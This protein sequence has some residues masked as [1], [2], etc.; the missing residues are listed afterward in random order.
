[1]VKVEISNQ[2][3]EDFLEEKNNLESTLSTIEIL[4]DEELLREIDTANEEIERGDCRVMS[5]KEIDNL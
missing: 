4:Q 5:Y 1:M 2:L 3:Y